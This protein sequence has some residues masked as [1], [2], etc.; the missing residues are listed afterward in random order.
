MQV[1]AVV[2]WVC[3]K[4]CGAAVD[5]LK[6]GTGALVCE[7]DIYKVRA[8]TITYVGDHAARFPL[9]FDYAVPSLAFCGQTTSFS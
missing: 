6:R 1:A 5:A 7:V 8:G 4:Q 3:G 2:K 9:S